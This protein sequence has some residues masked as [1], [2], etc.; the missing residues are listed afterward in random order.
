MATDV[1]QE[2][3]DVSFPLGSD[4]ITLGPEGFLLSAKFVVQEDMIVEQ[5]IAVVFIGSL[6]LLDVGWCCP[7]GH[8]GRGRGEGRGKVG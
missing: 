5:V 6:E 1:I 2:S 7:S 3:G 4:G 8:G